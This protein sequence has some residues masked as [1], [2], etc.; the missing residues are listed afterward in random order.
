MALSSS[1]P[2]V[3]PNFSARFNRFSISSLGRR[4]FSAGFFW[5]PWCCFFCFLWALPPPPPPPPPSF[6]FPGVPSPLPP[7]PPLFLPL[8]C[9]L[10]LLGVG[11]PLTSTT[12]MPNRSARA[13]FLSANFLASTA[14]GASAAAA[15]AAAAVRVRHGHAAA[16]V[17]GGQAA[18]VDQRHFHF[19]HRG[20]GLWPRPRPEQQRQEHPPPQQQQRTGI[21]GQQDRHHRQPLRRRP[22][23]R[24]VRR[25]AG[26]GSAPEDVPSRPGPDRLRRAHGR[27]VP[28]C[29]APLV[30]LA[31]P[32]VH[33]PAHVPSLSPGHARRRGISGGSNDRRRRRPSCC[34]CCP[35]EQPG[36]DAAPPGPAS[37]A[38]APVAGQG[39]GPGPGPAGGHDDDNH[40]ASSTGAEVRAVHV[41]RREQH[42]LQ[43]CSLPHLLLSSGLPRPPALRL[44]VLPE[45][46]VPGWDHRRCRGR[47]YRK[48]YYYYYHHR[49]GAPTLQEASVGVHL[50]QQRRQ[51]QPRCGDG[52]RRR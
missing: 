47:R 42:Q 30:L 15:A 48:C 3:V 46:P 17:P 16:D 44:Q 43:G 5:P 9:F 21:I 31:A 35:G 8:P 32:Q 10:P 41:V 26:R 29:G 22:R 18:Q 28:G 39:P 27:A 45:R 24:R 36:D 7:P 19:P 49:G 38:P 52:R 50:F 11:L 37:A 40:R 2:C 14:D 34:R 6:L 12:G 25:R 23:P 13:A 4:G 20:R 1:M 33:R 51:P